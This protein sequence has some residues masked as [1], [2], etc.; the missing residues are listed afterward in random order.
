MML[1]GMKVVVTEYA[2][3]HVVRRVRGGYMNRWWIRAIVEEPASFIMTMHGK[4]ALMCHP[5][6]YE[7]LKAISQQNQYMPTFFAGD[8]DYSKS[9]HNTRR[10]WPMKASA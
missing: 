10:F 6:I 8:T 3:H 4:Q 5:V 9:E 7:K 2:T 1:L